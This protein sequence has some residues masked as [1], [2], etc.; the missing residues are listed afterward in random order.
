[1]QISLNPNCVFKKI[2]NSQIKSSASLALQIISYVALATLCGA[3]LY[4]AAILFGRMI[5]LTFPSQLSK[6]LDVYN[7]NFR[8]NLNRQN[9]EKYLQSKDFKR[10]ANT[11]RIYFNLNQ[12]SP[13]DA[14]RVIAQR[15]PT[16][17]G[18]RSEQ[19]DQ[20]KL[21]DLFGYKTSVFN[22]PE[23]R[24]TDRRSFNSD[25]NTAAVY[26]ETYLWNPPGGPNK[27]EI[28]CLSLPAPALDS[29]QQPHY[30]YYSP[31]GLFDD[32]KYTNEI[33]FLFRI[34][35]KALR[36]NKD[37][38]F[39]KAG[40]KRL[41]LSRFGQGNFLAALDSCDRSRAQDI[42]KENLGAF[43]E[44]IQDLQTSGL[45]VVLCE[46]GPLPDGVLPKELEVVQGDI[47]QKAEAGDLIINPWDPHSAPG[48]GNDGDRSFDGA[49]GKASGILLTQ[50]AW[51]NDKLKTI[52]ALEWLE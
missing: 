31:N 24:N 17:I 3:V 7:Q 30:H 36:D 19:Y 11:A 45:A 9:L 37:T 47:I 41:V 42:F 43:L 26:S 18:M 14:L 35:E 10:H 49:M 38:A 20:S 1:M 33:G 48:N 15:E 28:A 34:I 6:V 16:N 22:D 46:Y 50:T 52:Q 27:K 39:N 13:D 5:D 12:M 44:R 25:P 40:I 2:S 51:F 32:E 8:P 4:K 23:A 29:K 21:F